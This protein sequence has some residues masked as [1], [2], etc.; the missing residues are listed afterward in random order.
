MEMQ[1]VFK[2]IVLLLGE[3]PKTNQSDQAVMHNIFD[4]ILSCTSIEES[5]EFFSEQFLSAMVKYA[6]PNSCYSEIVFK[7]CINVL[8]VESLSSRL[9]TLPEIAKLIELSIDS[10]TDKTCLHADTCCMFLSNLTRLETSCEFISENITPLPETLRR[11][12]TAFTIVGYN[13]KCS[14]DQL[15][16]VFCNLSQVANIRN[17]MTLTENNIL[18]KLIPFMN[19][20]NQT[21]RIGIIGVVHNCAFDTS[22][23]S[24]LLSDEIDLL[25]RLLL[26]LAG[27][28]QFDDE[29]NDKLPIDLQFLPET[30]TRES[31]P[32]IR[33][34]LLETLNQLCATKF[35]RQFLRDHNAYIILRELH[36][37]E[38]NSSVLLACENVIDILIRTEE[39]IGFDH[40][41]TVDIP[42]D[43]KE[44]FNKLTSSE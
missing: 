34:Q 21:R 30:K 5:W 1:K 22:I 15:A 39:E 20:D 37:W 9:S 43:L 35:G 33:K 31:N 32:E 24:W 19:H 23:H 12:V 16:M 36:K 3:G 11:L 17:V 25:P 41:K 10:I 40:L 26:P 6:C 28:E 42:E 29:D 14:L 27:P 7:I 4:V 8:S 44:K 18:Q 38:E 2:D 13:P